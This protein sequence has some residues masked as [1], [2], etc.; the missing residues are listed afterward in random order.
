MS[1]KSAGLAKK[2]G[3]EDVRVY[4]Q[5]APGWKKAG[6]YLVSTIDFVMTGNIVLVDLRSH[7]AVSAGHIP[8]AVNIP[9]KELSRAKEKFPSS[10]VAPIVFYSDNI[11]DSKEAVNL[12]RKW[13]Y[14]NNI[15]FPFEGPKECVAKGYDIRTD[16]VAKDIHWVRKNG[17]GEIN[18]KDFDLALKTDAIKVI[19]VRGVDEYESGHFPGAINIPL[20]ALPQRLDEIPQDKFIAVHCKTGV[21]GEMA[22]LL[23][24]EKGYAVKYL[25]ARCKCKPDGTYWIWE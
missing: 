20:D 4:S 19:D 6:N 17:P 21:R 18:M 25:N 3:Y 22:Y 13:G 5:G 24:K 11:E 2:W 8:R 23:L 12:A 10:K 9:L 16:E 7:Q 14:K 1:P 15:V